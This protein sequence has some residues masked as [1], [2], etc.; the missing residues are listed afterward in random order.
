MEKPLLGKQP[1]LMGVNTWQAQVSQ[2]P[3]LMRT[4]NV[5]GTG[6]AET[7]PYENL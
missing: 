7:A 5:A 1:P 4:Y 6:F 2:K 3:P